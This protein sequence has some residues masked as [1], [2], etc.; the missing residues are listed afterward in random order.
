MGKKRGGNQLPDRKG[1]SPYRVS[2]P[3]FVRDDEIGLGDA[4]KRATSYLG[5]KPCGGCERRA[6]T[7]NRWIILTGRDK[8]QYLQP[9]SST[10]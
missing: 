1:H 3:G 6:A 10:R 2:L 4:I 7:L 8:W 9:L 5:V